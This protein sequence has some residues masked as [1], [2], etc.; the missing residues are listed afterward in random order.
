MKKRD[1]FTRAFAVFAASLAFSAPASAA[2]IAIDDSNLNTITIN[3]GQFE[4]GFW[5]NGNLL[6]SGYGTGSITLIDGTP[7]TISGNWIDLNVTGAG[8]TIA[9]LFAPSSGT[10]YTSGMLLNAATHS[11]NHGSLSGTIEGYDPS[12]N[13]ATTYPTVLQDG[14]METS[15]LPYMSISFVSEATPVPEPATMLLFGTGIAGLAAAG[16]RKR[17]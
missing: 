4:S 8:T 5:V 11:Y 14:H 2:F 13:F 3:A 10:S 12:V 17:N 6:T 7:I 9:M 1:G 15:S 16:R